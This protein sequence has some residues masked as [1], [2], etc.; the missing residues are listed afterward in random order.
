MDANPVAEWRYAADFPADRLDLLLGAHSFGDVRDRVVEEARFLCC[1]VQCC[2][3]NPAFAR[4]AFCF[5]VSPDAFDLF[6]NSP[7]GYRG[8]YFRSPHE[9]LAANED[10]IAAMLPKLT[11]AIPPEADTSEC[12]FVWES[13]TSPTVKAWLA[14]IG[15]GHCARCAG[16]WGNPS[17][18]MPEIVN[19]RWEVANCASAIRGRKA[20]RLT[21]IRFFGA[22]LDDRYNEWISGRKRHRAWQIY[23]WGWS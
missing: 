13:L 16:E 11:A 7:V 15:L 9:G 3:E 18:G 2:E 1:H 6:Y 20:P 12:Q 5:E 21:K 23:R 4:V 19:G 8:S 22:F 10:L 14:E 17:D